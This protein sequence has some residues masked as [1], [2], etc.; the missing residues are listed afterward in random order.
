MHT[1]V[2]H[3][4][5]VEQTSPVGDSCTTLQTDAIGIAVDANQAGHSRI[6]FIAVVVWSIMPYFS[7]HVWKSQIN[8]LESKQSI[9][10]VIE[11]VSI[12]A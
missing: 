6:L 1:N 2:P 4:V 3:I 7:V 12:D 10:N 11:K 8:S 9:F 5:H